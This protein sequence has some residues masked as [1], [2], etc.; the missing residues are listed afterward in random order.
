MRRQLIALTCLAAL[1][2]CTAVAG[3]IRDRQEMDRV[4]WKNSVK[5]RNFNG[6]PRN[7]VIFYGGFHGT[8]NDFIF[9]QVD[10][11]HESDTQALGGEECFISMPVRFG[12]RYVLEYWCWTDGTETNEGSTVAR[13]YTEEDSPL[14]I[15]I[16]FEP[17]FYYFGYYDGRP[18]IVKGELTEWEGHPSVEMKPEVLRKALKCYRG[19]EWAPLLKEEL[20]QA[21]AEAKRHKAERRA[22]K[23]NG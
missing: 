10:P 7:T 21:E 12:T 13:S 18:S 23:R 4:V 14:V 5:Y 3:R 17:G 20:R 19:T 1:A 2:L 11:E 6:N 22:A 8:G 16:P 9:R 15:D